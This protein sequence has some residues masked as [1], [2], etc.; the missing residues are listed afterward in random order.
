MLDAFDRIAAH[1][2]ALGA[3]LITG[4]GAI[5]EVRL[6]GIT[7]LERLDERAPTLS[8]VH[9]RLPS[10]D[11]AAR[12]AEQG[13]FTWPGH[14]YALTL[15]ERLGLEPDG[16]LR[17]GPLHYNTLAEVERLVAAVAAL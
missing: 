5:E 15:S 10:R 16:M 12:L 8:F 7:D 4:L 1:E 9:A 2:R 13:I 6:L 3:A 17:V 14:H 11:V